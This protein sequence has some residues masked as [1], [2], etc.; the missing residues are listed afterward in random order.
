MREQGYTTAYFGKWHLSM[1]GAVGCPRARREPR[2]ATTSRP[3]GFDYSA[4][5]P[6]LEPAGYNDGVYN[7]PLWTKQAVDWLAEHGGDEKPWF[8]VVSLLNPHDIAY[9][10]RGF[11]VDVTRPDWQV[12][13]PPN[14]EDDPATQADGPPP[15]RQ[16]RGADPRRHQPTTTRRRGCG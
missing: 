10:P 15:V 5:S 6:S 9:F 3:Y 14:F 12:Q 7:D 11:S 1:A 13:L 16:R 8:L 2:R 4:Q